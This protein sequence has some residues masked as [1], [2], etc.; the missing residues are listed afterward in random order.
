M[1]VKDLKKALEQK[2]KTLAELNKQCRHTWRVC[3]DCM[4]HCEFKDTEQFKGK[5]LSLED[6]EAFLVELF[7]EKVIVPRKQLEYIYTSVLAKPHSAR[8]VL[9]ELLEATQK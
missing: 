7:L 9:K 4:A 6:V 3:K 8:L 1:S 5:W 2:A